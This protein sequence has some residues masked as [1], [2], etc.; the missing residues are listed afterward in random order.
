[1][2][3]VLIKWGDIIRRATVRYSS[4]YETHM[5][6]AGYDLVLTNN[7]YYDV[8]EIHELLFGIDEV[9][10]ENA[11]K[12]CLLIDSIKGYMKFIIDRIS[13][14]IHDD[15]CVLECDSFNHDD[16][17]GVIDDFIDKPIHVDLIKYFN[18]E[19]TNDDV[20]ILYSQLNTFMKLVLHDLNNLDSYWP[21]TNIKSAKK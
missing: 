10:E 2:L 9:T 4:Y 1:M 7:I 11:N 21:H 8:Q 3:E 20:D 16:N 15:R 14:C 19:L 12:G 5:V 17:N 13:L 18:R 6:N